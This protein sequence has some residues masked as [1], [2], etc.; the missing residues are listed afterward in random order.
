MTVWRRRNK[1]EPKTREPWLTEKQTEILLEVILNIIGQTVKDK[2]I[3]A[4]IVGALAVGTSYVTGE[5]GADALL[6]L[7]VGSSE[8]K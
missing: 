4:A 3:R 6:S 7:L 8:S 1:N 2:L 5:G